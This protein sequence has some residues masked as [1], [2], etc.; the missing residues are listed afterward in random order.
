MLRTKI[1]FAVV[2]L[3][4]TPF[5]AIAPSE[6]QAA[7]SQSIPPM[8]EAGYQHTCVLDVGA[9][10]C[11]G[12]NFNG[13][14]G[15]GDTN[16]RGDN[17]GEMGTAL[18]AV[19]LGAGVTATAVTAGG[20]HS[21]ALLSTG[22]V[23]CWGSNLYGQLGL[24]D[25]N[26]RGDGP[27]EMG[28]ALPAVDLG[29]GVTA[30]AISVGTYHSCALLSSGAVKCWGANDRGQ[31]GVGDTD[32]RGNGVGA[33]GDA[34][35]SA[36]QVTRFPQT[37]SFD[38]LPKRLFAAA[39]FTVTALSS[40]NLPVTLT[41][42]TPSVCSTSGFEVTMLK[43]GTCTVTASQAG[44]P[45]IIA[46]E[47]SQSFTVSALPYVKKGRQSTLSSVAR[48]SLLTV[49]RGANVSG[50]VARASRSV[51]RV[52][53]T[54][55]VGVAPGRCRLRITVTPKTGRSTKRWVVVNVSGSPTVRRSSSVSLLQA[56]AAANMTT[57]TG[58]SIQG[59]VA[60]SSKKVC[61]VSGSKIRG[62][63]AG[64]CRVTVTVTSAGGATATKRLNIYMR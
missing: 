49:P 13:Q 14:L 7:Q 50:V 9:V 1:L 36:F 2:G 23:K 28:D 17:P 62:V 37:I 19:D 24:G 46:A 8:V 54:R 25:T 39:P 40:L 31:L 52:S 35:L 63:G 12:E 56:A 38:A 47:V 48:K 20:Y 5:V 51:C 32:P 44:A 10:K 58:L 21:C 27:N 15:V 11:W 30:T 29:V 53:G 57:G 22:A 60:S 55:L 41:S 16:D 43:T 3:L 59:T 34:L 18:L 64:R 26:S 61:K 4:I 42:S 6:V 33:M 45:H